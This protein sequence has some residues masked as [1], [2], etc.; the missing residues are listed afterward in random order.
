MSI[1]ISR[2]GI[3][4]RH[5]TKRFLYWDYLFSGTRREEDGTI[6]HEANI[7]P[8]KG[9][10]FGIAV[11]PGYDKAWFDNRVVELGTKAVQWDKLK[12]HGLNGGQIGKRLLPLR[13]AFVHRPGI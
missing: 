7:I 1:S 9:D 2:T 8:R 11:A 4:G 12:Y 3:T 6:T 13:A 5:W 10:S